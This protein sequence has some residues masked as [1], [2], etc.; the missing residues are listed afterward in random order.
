[1]M[2]RGLTSGVAACVAAT[3]IACGD[4]RAGYVIDSVRSPEEELARFR[5]GIT[6]PPTALEGG[7]ASRGALIAA[8]AAAVSA[9]DSTTLKRMQLSRAEFAYLYYPESQFTRPPYRHPP[10]AAWLQLRMGD[11]GLRRLLARR[12]ATPLKIASHA[13]DPRPIEEGR[14][15]LWRRCTVRLVGDTVQMTLFGVI[16]E[17][18]GRFKFASFA[19][20][21]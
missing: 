19:N 3:L 6:E 2:A 17:R 20:D 11:A 15:R 18:E 21:L 5:E 13:C 16:I 9:G 8:F 10:E 12:T 4:V 14:S 7:A 1:M